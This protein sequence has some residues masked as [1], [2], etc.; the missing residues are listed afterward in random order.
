MQKNK[1]VIPEFGNLSKTIALLVI[2]ATVL[3]LWFNVPNSGKLPDQIRGSLGL[4][5]ET[6]IGIITAHLLHETWEHYETNMEYM[7]ALLFFAFICE[8]SRP[9]LRKT[10]PL[11]LLIP[12]LASH[13]IILIFDRFFP[14]FQFSVGLS[15]FLYQ[16]LG[17]FGMFVVF[18]LKE[19]D[20]QI[21][22]WLQD[23]KMGGN[24]AWI[25]TISVWLLLF[26]FGVVILNLTWGVVADVL[27]ISSSGFAHFI[28]F[29]MG[30]IAGYFFNLD[31]RNKQ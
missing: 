22:S 29:A 12:M 4:S 24:D 7:L 27:N 11:W 14:Y 30:I 28:G 5:Q 17:F 15:V 20:A 31:F 6:P 23:W 8:S 18:N 3:Y 16:A 1:L 9:E 19:L 13:A 2:L 26:T 25:R 10:N 21:K